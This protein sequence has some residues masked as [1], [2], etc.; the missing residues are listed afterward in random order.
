MV[1]AVIAA[2][3]L[4]RMVVSLR[5][6]LVADDFA[7]RYWAATQPL[8]YDYLFQSYGGHVNPIGLLNQWILQALF[9][10]S[11]IALV[12]FTTALTLAA[13]G[14]MAWMVWDITERIVGPIVVVLM[15][16]TLLFG[17]ESYLWWAAS[18]YAAPYLLFT[19]AGAFFVVRWLRSGRDRWI[20]VAVCC[21]VAASFSFSRGFM[22]IVLM[23][24]V[25]AA[26]PVRRGGALGPL[27]AWRSKPTA[28]LSM[29][30]GATLA[31][32]LV[33]V[34]SARISRDGFSWLALPRYFWNLLIFNVFPAIWGGPWRWFEI[35]GQVWTPVTANPAPAWWAVWLFVGLTAT[36]TVFLVIRR[37]DLRWLTAGTW[38]FTML[39][40]LVAALARS[41]TAVESVAYRYTFDVVLPVALLFTLAV[42][43]V[44]WRKSGTSRIGLVIVAA[45]VASAVLSTLVPARAWMSNLAK[46][47]MA[48]AVNGFERIPA[49]QVVL[50]QGVPFDLIHPGLMAPYASAEVVMT[51]Q[52]G[53]PAF[54][55]VASD[56][57]FGFAS[58]GTVQE[59]D[60]EGP[61]SVP[62]P[63]PDCGYRVTNAP[64]TIPLQGDLIAW[65][66]YAR[67]AYFSERGGT[68]NLAVGGVIHTVPLQPGGLRAVYFRVNGPGS[69]VLVSSGTPGATVCVTE[70]RIGNRV[71]MQSRELV[72]LPVNRLAE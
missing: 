2:V 26:V 34:N 61:G 37:P 10:G 24:I 57:L 66:F 43:P 20:W 18:I 58:D 44:R 56:K 32:I 15:M 63:D 14:F 50:N 12:L 65:D 17:L 59:Q 60:V 19:C 4:A 49:G 52:P 45:V 68:L 39:V 54:G 11:H 40:L 27:A 7:F 13:F 8:G 51:P 53:A 28:W 71:G 38:V 29:T 16:G 41:G 33:L 69:D 62:G 36:A 6:Y 9:P 72:P 35:P 46:P 67:V 23:F 30:A 21:A 70:L 3:V 25:A 31:V 1:A 55:D 5:G 64:R 22:A 42:V 47:Y 48:N